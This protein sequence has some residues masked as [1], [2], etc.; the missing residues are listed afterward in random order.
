MAAAASNKT[1]GA[2]AAYGADIAGLRI[3]ATMETDVDEALALSYKSDAIHIYSSSWGPTDDG[4]RLEG[5][6]SLTQMALENTVRTGRGGLGNI[7]VWAGGNGK[8]RGDNANYDGYA[9][10]RYTIAVGATDHKGKQAYYSESGAPLIACAPSDGDSAYITT[11]NLSACKYDFGGTSAVAPMISGVIALMLHANP[12]LGWR[13]VQH[14]LIHSAEQNDP[15]DS[16][17][18]L[19]GAGL[20]VNHKYGFGRV[21][22]AKAVDLSYK[23]QNAPKEPTTSFGVGK[24]DQLIPDNDSAGVSSAISISDSFR[25]EHVEVIFQATHPYRGDLKIVLTSPSGTQSVLAELHSDSNA[26]YDNWKFMSARHWGESSAGTWTLN[27]SDLRSGN[28]GTFDTWG[29]ILYG[30][31]PDLSDVI[32]ISRLIADIPTAGK[33]MIDVNRDKKVGMEELIWLLQY[34]AGLRQ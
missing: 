28:T 24:V 6:G 29:L 25:L 2:G 32:G 18:K 21:N 13:D 34:L 7:Y 3:V 27:V 22:A 4:K 1:C 23:W 14:I 10:S 20:H 30:N 8:L 15:T 26:D 9:N 19:N 12:K 17:W 33:F 31:Y 5:P 16:D 11:I